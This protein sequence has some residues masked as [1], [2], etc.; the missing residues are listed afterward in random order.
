MLSA[1]DGVGPS[2]SVADEPLSKLADL[3]PMRSPKNA[4]GKHL[5]NSRKFPRAL[6]GEDDGEAPIE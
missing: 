2:G 6:A 5:L 3:S 4:M 1:T